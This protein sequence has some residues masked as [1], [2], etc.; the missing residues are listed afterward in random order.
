MSKKTTEP[1][2]RPKE[3]AFLVG[4]DVYGS[5]DLLPLDAS[6]NELA[7]LAETAGLDVVG[8]VTQKLNHPTPRLLS[9]LEKLKK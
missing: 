2:T 3:R 9:A 1:T 4:V 8:E 7:L 5:D 6:L